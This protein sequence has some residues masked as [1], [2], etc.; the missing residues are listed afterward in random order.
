MASSTTIIQYQKIHMLYA[1]N[2]LPHSRFVDNDAPQPI[3]PAA[4]ATREDPPCSED[5]K[6]RHG[7]GGSTADTA[8]QRTSTQARPDTKEQK[9]PALPS[10]P[11]PSAD[12]ITRRNRLQ[13]VDEMANT[14]AASGDTKFMEKYIFI[15]IFLTSS[16]S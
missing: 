7:G 8:E 15:C 2:H 6:P 11:L 5:A 10:P 3:E 1:K 16:Y 9:P 13:A 14:T 12:L 4:P